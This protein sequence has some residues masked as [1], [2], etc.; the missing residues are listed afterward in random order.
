MFNPIVI[1]AFIVI[2]VI[3]AILLGFKMNGKRLKRFWAMVWIL[4]VLS[5][6]LIPVGYF[7]YGDGGN[8]PFDIEMKE[9]AAIMLWGWF[10]I[11]PVLGISCLSPV[12]TVVFWK[13]LDAKT[14]IHGL[15]YPVQILGASFVSMCIL[16]F[17]FEM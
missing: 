11:F 4:F 16:A 2:V 10:G 6:V 3:T 5:H 8:E 15:L 17:I 12:F 14:R 1:A 13:E 9:L 7:G